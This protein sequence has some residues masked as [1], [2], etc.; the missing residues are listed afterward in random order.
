MKVLFGFVLLVLVGAS[1]AC[2]LG[3]GNPAQVSEETQELVE[4]PTPTSKPTVSRVDFEQAVLIACKSTVDW[5]NSDI[6]EE[7]D[8]PS[9]GIDGCVE[10]LVEEWCDQVDCTWPGPNGEPSDGFEAAQTAHVAVSGSVSVDPSDRFVNRFLAALES[11][12]VSRGIAP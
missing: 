8:I 3:Q 12:R 9:E 5:W 7:G 1:L 6:S 10:A 2:L 11:Q 4:A